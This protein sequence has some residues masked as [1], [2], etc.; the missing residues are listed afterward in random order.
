MR[1]F[2]KLLMKVDVEGLSRKSNNGLDFCKV[3]LH[4]S[5]V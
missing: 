3:Q 1:S 2:G 4:R 5:I